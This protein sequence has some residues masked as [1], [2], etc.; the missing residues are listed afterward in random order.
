MLDGE[1]VFPLAAVE[2]R[3]LGALMEKSV[4][5]PEYYP[6]T[7][8]SLLAACNQRTSRE[9]VTDFGEDE[10]TDALDVLRAKGFVR[11]VDM[12]GARAPKFRHIADEALELDRPSYALLTVLFLRG[13]Q[14]PG[15]LRARTERLHAFRDVGAVQEALE[16]M[17]DREAEPH[18]LVCALPR[19]AGSKEIRY[20]QVLGGPTDEGGVEEG[21]VA[22]EPATADA[23]NSGIGRGS[24]IEALEA[25]VQTLEDALEALRQEFA[26]FRK[27]F[28]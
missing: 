20:A 24:R 12:A 4:T 13:P 28:E 10:V 23:G 25:R 27:E 15:Q 21:G 3:V 26:A 7:L 9:P 17:Q 6:M 5:T 22:D 18:E 1:S 2:L 11:R 19:R 14:T 8:N 16:A